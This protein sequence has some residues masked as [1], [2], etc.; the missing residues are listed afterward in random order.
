MFLS[1]LKTYYWQCSAES[2]YDDE[3]LINFIQRQNWNNYCLTLCSLNIKDNLFKLRLIV[4]YTKTQK[5]IFIRRAK[6]FQIRLLYILFRWIEQLLLLYSLTCSGNF[7]KVW[8][9][10]WLFL[11]LRSIEVAPGDGYDNNRNK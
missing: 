10:V 11:V 4:S 2:C 5:P 6:L 9:I 1:D 7:G 3:C 8:K